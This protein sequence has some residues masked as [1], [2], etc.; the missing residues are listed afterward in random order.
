MSRTSGRTGDKSPDHDDAARAASIQGRFKLLSELANGKRAL[1]DTERTRMLQALGSQAGLAALSDPNAGIES[2]SLNTLKAHANANPE[3]G[4]A[5]LDS[6]R[7]A[8]LLR[9]RKEI[10]DDARPTRGTRED[11]SARVKLQSRELST[12]TD[13][14]ALMTQRLSDYI[15]IA[16]EFAKAAGQ[17]E[18]FAK[19]QRELLQK[20]GGASQQ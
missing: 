7:R 14:L 10:S 6:L 8:A 13:E 5:G 9:L 17:L 1:P 3:I 19:K 12:L 2:M 11:L 20:Y 4:F 16:R 15:D 18:L